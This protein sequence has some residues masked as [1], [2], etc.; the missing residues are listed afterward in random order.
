MIASLTWLKDDRSCLVNSIDLCQLVSIVSIV[1]GSH[2]CAAGS[3][4]THALAGRRNPRKSVALSPLVLIALMLVRLPYMHCS[5]KT[6][7]LTRWS[8]Q[9]SRYSRDDIDDCIPYVA[10]RQP[11]LSWEFYCSLSIGVDCFD[12]DRLAYMRCSH[13]CA[14]RSL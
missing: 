13:T 3:L 1:V 7:A 5:F 14:A 11:Q 12:G 6:D 8:K 4:W 10:Q 9:W 2:T